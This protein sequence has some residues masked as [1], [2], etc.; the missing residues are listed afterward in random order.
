MEKEFDIEIN[1][2][3]LTGRLCYNKQTGKI[4]LP[5]GWKSAAKKPSEDE[6]ISNLPDELTHE[7]LHKWL[8]E[9]IGDI[10]CEAWDNLD[11]IAGSPK[12]VFSS[13]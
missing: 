6:L 11:K 9:N 1:K 8:Y 3:S 7:I 2:Y 5:N 12:Y 4:L 10:E 13:H